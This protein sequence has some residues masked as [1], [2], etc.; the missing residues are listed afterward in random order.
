MSNTTIT[1]E[2]VVGLRFDN[3]DFAKSV[4]NTMSLLDKLHYSVENLK[5]AG[6]S[7]LFFAN[8]IKSV[9][10][11]P[12]A[13]GCQVGIGKIMALTAAL[14][15]VSNVA[16]E[17]YHKMT[18]LIK[19]MSTDQISAGWTKYADY[20]SSM[21]TIMSATKKDGE[22]DAEAM[23]RVNKEMEKLLWFTDET[24]YNLTDMTSNIGYSLIENS[25]CI[26]SLLINNTPVGP[27]LDL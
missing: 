7:V 10:F 24:S 25:V 27:V 17:V 8:Q 2:R 23:A 19:S 4:R 9:T 6:N 3:K 18:T 22:S 26:Y 15:G 5:G 13:R 1:E 21:Q 11:D 20:T 14:T 16:D 12:L